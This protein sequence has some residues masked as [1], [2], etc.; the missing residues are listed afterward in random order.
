[1]PAD[2]RKLST[3]RPAAPTDHRFL[4]NATDRLVYVNRTDQ[5]I[6]PGNAWWS[7]GDHSINFC[8]SGGSNPNTAFGSVIYHEYGHHVVKTIMPQ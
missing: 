3:H 1:M 4:L 2:Q 8:L 6:C 5:P 7:S